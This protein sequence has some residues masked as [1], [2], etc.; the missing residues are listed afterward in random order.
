MNGV[1]TSWVQKVSANKSEEVAIFATRKFS[2]RFISFIVIMSM[3]VP[4][5]QPAPHV[6][7][8][9]KDGLRR[10]TNAESGRV[11]FISSESGGAVPAAQALGILP[12]QGHPADP[13]LALA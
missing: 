2:P 13:A 1:F 3:M 4:A 5:I 11:S 9:A 10:R 6:A 7:A 8:L 12:G